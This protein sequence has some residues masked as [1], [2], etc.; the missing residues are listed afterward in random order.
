MPIEGRDLMLIFLEVLIENELNM[1]WETVDSEYDGPLEITERSVDDEYAG[2]IVKHEDFLEFSISY[3]SHIG[4]RTPSDSIL[5][6]LDYDYT[7]DAVDEDIYYNELCN[8][9]EKFADDI[10]KIGKILDMDT[11]RIRVM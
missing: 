8:F 6:F 5:A 4:G 9:V 3:A 10:E 11:D 7:N 2:L 1:K